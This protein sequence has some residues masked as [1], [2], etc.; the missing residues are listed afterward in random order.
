[1]KRPDI[2]LTA[3]AGKSAD[4]HWVT[5]TSTPGLA[6][7]LLR[8]PQDAAASNEPEHAIRCRACLHELTADKYIMSVEGSHEHMQC[9]PYGI[10]FVFGCFRDAPGCL[11]AGEAEQ[12]DSWFG[13]YHWQMALC[14]NCGRH[15]GWC[16]TSASAQPFFGLILARLQSGGT[17]E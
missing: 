2:I 10:T 4:D 6:E 13:Q 16:F 5:A 3:E 11:V 7:D 12:E 14:D 8:E 1:M 17:S 9:N 15:L